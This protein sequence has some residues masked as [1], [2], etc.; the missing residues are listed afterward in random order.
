MRR[1]CKTMI[2]FCLCLL[3]AGC[4]DSG[5]EAQNAVAAV[6]Y[7]DALGKNVELTQEDVDRIRADEC[8]V[9]VC[10]G[11]LAQIWSAAGGKLWATTQDAYDDT[12]KIAIDQDTVNL[13]SLKNPNLELL[14]EE[15]IEVVILS[16]D[17]E[18][19]V[20][21]RE[22]LESQG[23]RTI[24]NSV[25]TFR[26][27]LAVLKLYTEIT[28]C[29][30]RYE[31]YGASVE[32]Q[33]EEQLARQDDSHPTVLFIRA[34]STG[35]K[36]KGSDSMTGIMLRELGCVNIA[37]GDDRLTDELSMEIIL[38]KDPDYIFV[39]TMGEDETA[40]FNSVKSLLLDNPAWNSLKA[41]QNGNYYVLP[42]NLFHNKPNE[43]WGES[44]QM[45][46][47]ILYPE[48]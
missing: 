26:D 21:L 44:Y 28:G 3:T 27:Y 41:V 23:L 13:G 31:Q 16:A 35:A 15:E 11:S 22:K 37:D 4:G 30:E 6:S 1:I 46:A 14:L 9:A 8:K 2:I 43:R 42:K 5:T 18:D 38:E 10:S 17:L 33:I 7:T 48:K 34:F 36:A 29:G 45:L 19:H 32:K 40:A 12:R 24:Y 47:D 25:E 39:T 20:A